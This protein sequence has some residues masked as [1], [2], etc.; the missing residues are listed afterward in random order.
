MRRKNQDENPWSGFTGGMFLVSPS[1]SVSLWCVFFLFFF[2]VKQWGLLLPVPPSL[3]PLPTLHRGGQEVVI[4][5]QSLVLT[6]FHGRWGTGDITNQLQM[7]FEGCNICQK[8]NWLAHVGMITMPQIGVKPCH[9]P[10]SPIEASYA[11]RY[12]GCGYIQ[13]VHILLMLICYVHNTVGSSFLCLFRASL[14]W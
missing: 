13:T 2:G 8:A 3:V 6:A 11:K 10:R 9:A 5:P 4:T 1:V 14:L 12:K 7:R